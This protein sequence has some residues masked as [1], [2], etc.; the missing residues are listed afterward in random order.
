MSGAAGTYRIH[1]THIPHV[2]VTILTPH[3]TR[4]LDTCS[5]SISSNRYRIM[6]TQSGPSYIYKIVVQP[7]S[8]QYSRDFEVS[9]ICRSMR[10]VM[11]LLQPTPL[12]NTIWSAS[13]IHI[14]TKL[15]DGP[16]VLSALCGW[17]WNSSSSII[18]PIVPDD[19]SGSGVTSPAA[20]ASTCSST[21]E[22]PNSAM[23]SSCMHP[24]TGSLEAP[25]GNGR[26]ALRGVDIGVCIPPLQVEVTVADDNCGK[27]AWI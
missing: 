26:Q 13:P 3:L 7:I 27:A 16:G 24:L 17:D 18:S 15:T 14:Q 25:D 12:E 1:F 21:S 11:W 22:P 5:K 2:N 10:I 6:W 4:T 9:E 20:S 8:T 23:T 19:I